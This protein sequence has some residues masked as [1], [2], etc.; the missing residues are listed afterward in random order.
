MLLLGPTI[1][2]GINFSFSKVY[3]SNSRRT[4]GPLVRPQECGDPPLA[5]GARESWTLVQDITCVSENDWSMEPPDD[6][7][8]MVLEEETEADKLTPKHA[9][10]KTQQS[11]NLVGT[12]GFTPH[13][14]EV[15]SEHQSKG[16]GSLADEEKVWVDGERQGRRK[17]CTTKGKSRSTSRRERSK[18]AR[19]NANVNGQFEEVV[20]T[21]LSQTETAQVHFNF[22][23]VTYNYGSCQSGA[24]AAAAATATATPPHF[25]FFNSNTSHSFP[26]TYH[27]SEAEGGP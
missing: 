8:P 16:G 9:T 26:C 7:T 15:E 27:G 10:F 23:P 13:K 1:A 14:G 24:T 18:S 12:S 4:L 25:T 19:R 21:V 22:G 17:E 2:P 11:N 3:N 20:S 5:P 6:K